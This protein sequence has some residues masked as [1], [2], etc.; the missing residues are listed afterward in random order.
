MVLDCEITGLGQDPALVNELLEAALVDQAGVD[1]VVIYNVPSDLSV[2]PP[3]SAR[4]PRPPKLRRRLRRARSSECVPRRKVPPFLK[5][6]RGAQREARRLTL[7]DDGLS[8]R[9]V[10]S[11]STLASG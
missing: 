6:R 7:V 10:V 11:S 5:M 4:R 1:L 9:P 2:L 3:S 8:S